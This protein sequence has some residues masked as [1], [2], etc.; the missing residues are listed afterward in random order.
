MFLAI[1]PAAVAGHARK[2]TTETIIE[3]P[4]WEDAGLAQIAHK[5]AVATL[6]RL[7][8]QGEVSVMG[9]DDTRIATLNAAFR[10]KATPTNVLSWPSEERGAVEDGGTPLAPTDPELG[11]IAIAYETCAREAE[12]QGKTI[13]EHTTHLIVHGVLHLL[14]YDHERDRDAALMEGLETEILGNMGIAD[15]YSS[16]RRTP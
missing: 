1:D 15:P 7:G 14:G 11:D 13:G 9:C 2:M 12:A 6:G 10:D 4:R 3:D 16:E 8:V 5:A